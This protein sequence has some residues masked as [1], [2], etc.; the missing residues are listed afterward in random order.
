MSA[1]AEVAQP[2]RVRTAA[3]AGGSAAGRRRE[4]RWALIFLAPALVLVVGFVAFPIG[5]SGYLSF[6][7]WDGSSPKRFIGF[8]NFQKL[9]TDGQFWHS[10]ENNALIAVSALVA[11]VFLGLVIAYSLVRIV[12]SLKRVY[13]FCY[14]V[15]VVVSEICI[16]LIWSFIYN[17]TFGPLN[18]LLKVLGLKALSHGW[19]GDQHTAFAAVLVTMSFTYLGLYVLLFV[20]SMQNVPESLYEAAL[21][22]G[23]GS[24]RMFFSITVPSIADSIQSTTLLAVIT[25]FKTFSLVYV[26]TGGGPDHA[27][28]VVST[29]LYKTGFITFDQGYA[30][31]LGFTQMLLTAVA[32]VLVFRGLRRNTNASRGPA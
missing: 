13:M 27:T 26:L 29:L 9:L 3:P 11:Q 22:D 31:T 28:E 30:A 15:P 19:L 1:P 12:P 20:S 14:M 2:S 23:A 5:Y 8:A 32:G 17:P 25:S 21:L 7:S 24:V 18:G 10:L 16:A 4:S 6:Y